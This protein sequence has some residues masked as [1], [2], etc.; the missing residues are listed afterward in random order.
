LVLKAF[1]KARAAAPDEPFVIIGHSLGGVITFDLLSHYRPE[2][3]VDLFV[4]VG[5]QV[6]HFEEL[7]LFKASDKSI[8]TPK[9]ATTPANIK[10][11]INI[12]DEVDIFS[13]AAERV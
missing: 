5:S 7:K 12:Y 6:A 2:L 11:W 13:Y 10:R 8:G 3:E 1:D 4:S 9:R